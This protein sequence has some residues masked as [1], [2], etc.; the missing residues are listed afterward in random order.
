M[1]VHVY[2]CVRVCECVIV[3]VCVGLCGLCVYVC[4]CK[5]FMFEIKHVIISQPNNDRSA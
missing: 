5:Y 4:V 2:A 1:C 3:C